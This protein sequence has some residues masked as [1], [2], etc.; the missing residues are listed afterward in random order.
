MGKAQQK[1][2]GIS[3]GRCFLWLKS[4]NTSD[5]ASEIPNFGAKHEHVSWKKD[6][7][8]IAE[9]KRQSPVLFYLGAASAIFLMLYLLVVLSPAKNSQETTKD[10]NRL[11]E[12][13]AR[14]TGR[15]S[16]QE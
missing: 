12:E 14:R 11:I 16:G 5:N 10:M 8:R 9:T 4:P 2:Q 15:S 7:T 1:N 6:D 3:L 13:L